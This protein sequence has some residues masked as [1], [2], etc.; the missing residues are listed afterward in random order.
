MI[1]PWSEE[2]TKAD[3]NVLLL[4]TPNNINVNT[5]LRMLV[6]RVPV[7]GPRVE[8]YPEIPAEAPSWNGRV[9]VIPR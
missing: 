5:T 6:A 7:K 3:V 9:E 8:P 4:P 1:T 2:Q